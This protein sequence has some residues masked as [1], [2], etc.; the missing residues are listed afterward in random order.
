MKLS[1]EDKIKI[2]ERRQSGVPLPALSR[3]YGVRLSNIKYLVS[4]I[5]QHGYDVLREGKNKSYTANYKEKVINRILINNESF[6]SVAL[7]EGLPS[8][9]M[10]HNWVSNYKKNGYNVIEKPKGRRPMT[11]KRDASPKKPLSELDQLKQENLYLK[12]EL[13][14]LKKLEAV[15][16]AKRLQQKKK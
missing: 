3:E 15:E 2:Y 8:N 16:R 11:K 1:R 9:G 4:L 5:D 10:L 6:N 7:D 13:E 12:A 14:Y